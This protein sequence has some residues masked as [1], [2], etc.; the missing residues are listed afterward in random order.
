MINPSDYP[1]NYDWLSE[2][3]KEIILKCANT[4]LQDI[5]DKNTP[6]FMK[7]WAKEQ[8]KIVY[9]ACLDN[10]IRLAYNWSGHRNQFILATEL[11]AEMEQDWQ[12]QC[13]DYD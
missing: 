7:E 3:D 4:L 10:N 11:D 8:L 9:Y 1:A 5:K 2:E 13:A 6:E 12:F